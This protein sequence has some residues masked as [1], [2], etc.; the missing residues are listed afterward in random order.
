MLTSQ[1][2]HEDRPVFLLQLAWVSA[3]LSFAM[4]GPTRSRTAVGD[5]APAVSAYV[6]AWGVSLLLTWAWWRRRPAG[7]RPLRGRAALGALLLAGLGVLPFLRE[8]DLGLEAERTALLAS[9]PILALLL[10]P[11]AA[12]LAHAARASLRTDPPG[13]PLP[14]PPPRQLLVALLPLGLVPLMAVALPQ[15]AIMEELR[16][17]IMNNGVRGVL[18]GQL[19]LWGPCGALLIGAGL[20]ALDGS[21][22]GRATRVLVALA[23][24]GALVGI[25]V[26]PAV[27]AYDPSFRVDPAAAQPRESAPLHAMMRAAPLFLL[28]LGLLLRRELMVLGQRGMQASLP[29]NLLLLGGGYLGTR[30]VAPLLGPEWAPLSAAL[31]CVLAYA[32][33]RRAV[34]IPR[35][36]R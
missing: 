29:R 15:G 14:P 24:L 30:F 18:F 7:A 8:N 31:A 27:A 32:L 33:P 26:G 21:R 28:C 17:R 2:P 25:A 34:V 35:T 4:T 12:R 22:E 13:G 16:G 10:C 23:T 6:L 36:A 19:A 9:V 5:P 20:D 11:V 1:P 3:L